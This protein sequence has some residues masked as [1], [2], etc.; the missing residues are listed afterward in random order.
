VYFLDHRQRL[1]DS[2][3]RPGE[4]PGGSAGMRHEPLPR[5]PCARDRR[6][7]SR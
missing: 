1:A 5:R 4:A 2:E 7:R 6:A 3:G